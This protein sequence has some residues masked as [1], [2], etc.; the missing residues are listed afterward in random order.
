MLIQKA[1][2]SRE[3]N[4]K[5]RHNLI[6]FTRIS[7]SANCDHFFFR[8]YSKFIESIVKS[9]FN[10][11]SRDWIPKRFKQD[12]HKYA[13]IQS[14][15]QKLQT[16]SRGRNQLVNNFRETL[17]VHANLLIWTQDIDSVH[18]YRATNPTNTFTHGSKLWLRAF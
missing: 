2:F 14:H 17:A 12:H 5:P 7:S 13:V 16:H 1:G 15:K 6:D 10:T 9:K 8:V 3:R 11:L 18:L 4:R